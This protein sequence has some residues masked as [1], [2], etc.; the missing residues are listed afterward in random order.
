MSAKPDYNKLRSETQFHWGVISSYD[1]LLALTGIPIKDFYLDPEAGIEAYRKGRPLLSEMFGPDVPPPGLAT[2]HVSYGHV[3]CLGAEMVFPEGG[4]VCNT[5]PFTTLKEGI[6]VLKRDIDFLNSGM[7]NFYLD[8]MKKLSD[9][10]DGEKCYFAFGYEGPITSAYTLRG[11]AVF[12]DPYDN[13]DLFK[14]FLGLLTESI[15]EFGYFHC[16]INEWPHISPEGAGLC[17]DVASMFNP[18]MWPEFVL[19]YWENY[20][21]AKTTGSRFAHVE[22][23]RVEQLHF[24]EDIGLSAYDPSISTK[25]NPQIISQA[26]QVPFQWRLGSIHYPGMSCQD[27]EDFVFQAIADGASSVFADASEPQCNPND[28]KKIH[29]F[30]RAAKVVERMLSEGATRED[31]GKCVSISGKQ[32]FWDHWPE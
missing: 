15:V 21:A 25:I 28:V 10:F 6:N 13:P 7:T 17:D 32:R 19:P 16:N 27:V 8:Y 18:D 14:E 30:I 2:P 29:S 9:A 23:L 4:E 5:V 24:L 20:F 1:T 31:I 3:N 26:C 22:D 12:F 11:H